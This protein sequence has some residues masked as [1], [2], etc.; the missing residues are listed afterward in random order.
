MRLS[1]LL[2]F[3]LLTAVH[4]DER[5]A[6]HAVAGP[7]N[8]LVVSGNA[9]GPAA[10]LTSFRCGDES[11]RAVSEAIPGK[12]DRSKLLYIIKAYG[13]KPSIS[14]KDRKRWTRH[15]INAEDLTQIAG[16]LAAVKASPAPRSDQ[17]FRKGREKPLKLVN[18]IHDHLRDSLKRG[19]PP[20]LS[21]KRY[22]H[23]QGQWQSLQGHFI[24]VVRVPEKIDRKA[25]SFTFTYFDPWKGKKHE[26]TFRIPTTPIISADGESSSCLE[27]FM[28][29]ADIGRKLLKGGERSFVVPVM[30]IG[31]W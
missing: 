4:A 29:S 6:P 3:L 30:V 13:L 16:E 18:R 7:V 27:S 8:Q 5:W 19:F 23:R 14:L 12:S 1:F 24:T 17:L 28:P 15:G 11:W 31:R 20:V 25:S 22:V 26:G 2:L 21:V 9:C 10:L